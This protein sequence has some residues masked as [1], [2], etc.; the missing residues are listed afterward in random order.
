LFTLWTATSPPRRRGELSSSPLSEESRGTL[1]DFGILAQA[2]VLAPQ[3]REFLS[4]L[5][6]ETLA[7]SGVDGGL[8]D[9]VSGGGFS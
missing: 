4:L 6:G 2:P 8:A 9:S 3:L 5:A 1:Q 7:F